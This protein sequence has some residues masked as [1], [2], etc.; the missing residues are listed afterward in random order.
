LPQALQSRPRKKT[1]ITGEKSG[2]GVKANIMNNPLRRTAIELVED[3]CDETKPPASAIETVGQ[4]NIHLRQL[5][6]E[7]ARPEESQDADAVLQ[8]LV[9]IAATSITTAAAH[10]LPAMETEGGLI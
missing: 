10:V 6:A 3:E 4:L 7:L 8:A 9:A 5:E 2:V 1:V